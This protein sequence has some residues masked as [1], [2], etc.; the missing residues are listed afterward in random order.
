MSD[1]EKVPDKNTLIKQVSYV[2][3][4]EK[5]TEKNNISDKKNIKKPLFA[6]SKKS[7]L[8]ISSKPYSSKDIILSIINIIS[9]IFLF[10]ILSKLKTASVEL[11]QV[12]N[13]IFQ[14]SQSPKISSIQLDNYDDKYEKLSTVFL[15]EAGV[16]DFISKVESLKTNGSSFV[17]ISFASQLAVKDKTGNYGYPVVISLKG[18]WESISKDLKIINDLNYL[19]RVVRFKSEY[20]QI[21]GTI[22]LDYGIMLYVKERESKSK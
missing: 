12:K 5:A 8:K 9:I 14:R 20:N 7:E 15:D 18:N 6:R 13:E 11:N 3:K 2:G 22:E 21:D 1:D 4:I 19:F 17:K 10:V 16:A